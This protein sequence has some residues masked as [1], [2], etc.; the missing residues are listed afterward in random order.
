[1]TRQAKK[2]RV[3][4][5]LEEANPGRVEAVVGGRHWKILA[6]GRLVGIYPLAPSKEGFAENTKSQLRN[7]GLVVEGR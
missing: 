6:G 4:R 5:T 7:A 2:P 3:L 1:M